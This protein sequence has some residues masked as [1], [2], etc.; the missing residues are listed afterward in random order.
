MPTHVLRRID[1]CSL[2]L[3]EVAGNDGKASSVGWHI[4][5]FDKQGI[6]HLVGHAKSETE[7][8]R[9][10]DAFKRYTTNPA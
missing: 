5:Q 10:A 7:A 4:V 6:R 2:K 9:K 3:I 1:Y 8:R